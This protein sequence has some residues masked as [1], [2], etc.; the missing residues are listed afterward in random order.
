MCGGWLLAIL[1]AAASVPVVPAAA[2]PEKKHRWSRH[3][4]AQEGEPAEPPV[5]APPTPEPG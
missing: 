4:I 5:E 3:K 1:L 2:E